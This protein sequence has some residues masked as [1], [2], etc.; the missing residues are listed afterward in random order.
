MIDEI[1]C[2]QSRFILKSARLKLYVWNHSLF[3]IL[4]S[5]YLRFVL[6]CC[7]NPCDGSSC[8]ESGIDLLLSSPG[9]PLTLNICTLFAVFSSWGSLYWHSWVC[10]RQS[11][12][13]VWS[14]QHLSLTEYCPSTIGWCSCG[15][16][17]WVCG[18]T[19]AKHRKS[20]PPEST[21]YCVTTD[22]I[23]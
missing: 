22:F 12:T 17:E 11:T 1:S 21:Q 7:R 23:D 10:G 5:C 6:P 20:N 13:A 8:R 2:S 19:P 16:M 3:V 18:A 14:Y 4:L 15:W 9:N